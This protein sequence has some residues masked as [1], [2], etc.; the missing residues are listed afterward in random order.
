MTGGPG[1]YVVRRLVLL[2]ITYIDGNAYMSIFEKR[3]GNHV[4][5]GHKNGTHVPLGCTIG[6]VRYEGTAGDE[7][8]FSKLYYN[9]RVV[10]YTICP[11]RGSM[12]REERAGT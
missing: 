1:G 11:N 7:G 2:K 4:T 3:P 12:L 10:L 9:L 6:V 5:M 8:V